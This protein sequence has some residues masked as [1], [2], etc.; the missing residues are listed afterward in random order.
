MNLLVWVVN[1]SG[2]SWQFWQIFKNILPLWWG[3][4]RRYE[5]TAP[6]PSP[7]PTLEV[8]EVRRLVDA[9]KILIHQ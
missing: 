1:I 3:G 5:T 7:G 9:K 8:T 6:L 2:R 4:G